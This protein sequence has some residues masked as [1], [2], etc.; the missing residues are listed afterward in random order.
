MATGWLHPKLLLPPNFDQQAQQS[1]VQHELA[2]VRHADLVWSVFYRIVCA[3][4]WFHPLAFVL[5]R[6]VHLWQEVVA[7]QSA[8]MAAA[9]SPAEH[10][11]LILAATRNEPTALI[12]TALSGDGRLVKRRMEAIFQ[13]GSGSKAL[14]LA[15]ILIGFAC[16]APAWVPY[17]RE[18]RSIPA[19]SRALAEPI[20]APSVEMATRAQ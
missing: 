1:A 11:V 12:A 8:C 7:D 5:E 3:V 16:L 18:V 2:H 9:T 10:A 19:R 20:N 15:G 6:E 14:L 17:S 4:F 13:Q